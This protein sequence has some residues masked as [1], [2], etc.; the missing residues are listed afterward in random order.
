MNQLYVY[1]CE[2]ITTIKLLNMS[3]TPQSFLMPLH[4]PF[5]P[6]QTCLQ[7][8]A[9]LLSLTFSLIFLE[10]YINRVIQ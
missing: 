5:L 10:F 2:T 6:P 1:I 8:S 3:I 7:V 9:D 4:S